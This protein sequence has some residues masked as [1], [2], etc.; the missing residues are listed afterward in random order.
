MDKWVHGNE[1]LPDG[2]PL[3]RSEIMIRAS[4]RRRIKAAGINLSQQVREWIDRDFP[5]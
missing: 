3:V 1:A 5:D 4:Q 2:D